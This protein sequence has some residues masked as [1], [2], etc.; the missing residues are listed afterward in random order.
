MSLLFSFFFVCFVVCIDMTLPQDCLL[1]R[2]CQ[3]CVSP[4]T[5]HED[6]RSAMAA[7]AGGNCRK[8][9]ASRVFCRSSFVFSF[10]VLSN[11]T[12]QADWRDFPQDRSTADIQGRPMTLPRDRRRTADRGLCRPL[13]GQLRGIV[14]IVGIRSHAQKHHGN[15]S[16]S[17]GSRT[18][19][20]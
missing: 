5:R 12:T 17:R 19:A 20:A 11:P 18:D 7:I 14:D 8:P 15:F 6:V 2:R 3:S 13:L 9:K 4:L 1:A 16:T 10:Y